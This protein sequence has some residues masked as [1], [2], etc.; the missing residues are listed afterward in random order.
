MSVSLRPS[1]ALIVASIALVVALGGTAYAVTSINGRTLVDH[2]VAGRKL[3]N[4]TVTGAQ[5]QESSLGMVRRAGDATTVDGTTVRQVFY[6]P[7]TATG[8]A[9]KLVSLGGLTIK[10]SCDPASTVGTVEIRATTAFTHARLMSEMFNSGGGGQA[11]GLHIPDFSAQTEDLTDSNDWGETSFTYTRAG[12][13]IVNGQLAFA[14][15]NN[16]TDGNIF[17]NT[18][19]CLVSGFVMSTASK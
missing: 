18:R 6:A 10:A 8:T 16:I 14:S 11:D 15:S 4:N 2:S 1:P 12:G 9:T 17:G 5:I 13:V 3:M 7:T 19:K